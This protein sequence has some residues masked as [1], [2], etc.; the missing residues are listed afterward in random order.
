MPEPTAFAEALKGTGP[1]G[2]LVGG[3]LALGWSHSDWPEYLR[4]K[5]A[6]VGFSFAFVGLL[7]PFLIFIY[8]LTGCRWLTR[9][10]NGTPLSS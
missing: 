5:V 10:A 1:M 6:L 9:F 2:V 7:W 8:R 4:E 3:G